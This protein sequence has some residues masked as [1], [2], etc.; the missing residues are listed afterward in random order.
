MSRSR[1]AAG[2]ATSR[3]SKRRSRRGPAGPSSAPRRRSSRRSSTRR[4]GSLAGPHSSSAVDA[5]DGQVAVRGWTH[6][7]PLTA[8][9]LARRA[10]AAGA[11]AV[12]YTDIPRDGTG[13]GPNLEATAALA[14][15]AVAA[16]H[17]LGRRRRASTTSSSW[18]RSPTSPGPSSVERSTPAP[19]TSARRSP[20]WRPD[21]HAGPARD[22]VSRRQGRPGRQGRAVPRPA[23]AG[24]PVEAAIAYDGKGRTS[25]CSSTSPPPTRG[26]PRCSTSCGARRRRSTCR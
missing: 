7:L 23:D 1:S 24:D 21:G 3:P 25:S 26:A 11:A 4:A 2:S 20:R 8:S 9:E 22:P 13:R 18:R 17:R 16:R 5:V 15:E 10:A 14:A 6:V 12:V 19:S